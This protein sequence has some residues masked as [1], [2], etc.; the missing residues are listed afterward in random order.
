M[1]LG[2]FNGYGSFNTRP[3]QGPTKWAPCKPHSMVFGVMKK[4]V[5]I[6]NYV[7][8]STFSGV[9]VGSMC[10]IFTKFSIFLALGQT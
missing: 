3:S 2:P 8:G 1:F 4:E 9:M 6:Q 10:L 5:N 7:F